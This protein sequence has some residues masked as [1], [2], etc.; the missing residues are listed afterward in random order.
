MQK[1]SFSVMCNY[2]NLRYGKLI[3]DFCKNVTSIRHLWLHSYQF[4]S[5]LIS[6]FNLNQIKHSLSNKARLL[7][8]YF[9]INFSLPPSFLL[10]F[11]FSSQARVRIYVCIQTLSISSIIYHL[12]DP[13]V[14]SPLQRRSDLR[15]WPA[16][17]L[18]ANANATRRSPRATPG[19]TA[20]DQ[21]PGAVSKPLIV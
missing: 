12:R 18:F 7:F 21:T 1:C 13:G 2:Y 5:N 3:C 9:S 19:F 11:S 4:L 17:R 20:R 15:S 6:H 16:A 8:V 10:I 14:P